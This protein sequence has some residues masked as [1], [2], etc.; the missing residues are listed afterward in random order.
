MW[1]IALV[2]ALLVC[3][4]PVMIGARIVRARRGG[5]VI[6]LLA[7]IVSYLIVGFALRLFHGLGALSIFAAAIGYML[8]LDTSYLRG[9][10]VAIIQNV[11]TVVLAVIVAAM[12]FGGVSHGVHR[13]LRDAPFR[14]DGPAENV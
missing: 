4:V 9:L 8:I 2:I 5:F 7:L 11:L 13:I 14:V 3:V 12:I 1:I 10:A 6:S